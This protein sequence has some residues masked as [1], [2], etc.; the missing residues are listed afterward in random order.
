VLVFALEGT[1][2]YPYCSKIRS[3]LCLQLTGTEVLEGQECNVWRLAVKEGGKRNVYTLWQSVATQL[4]VRYEMFGFDSLLGSHYDKYYIDYIH[5]DVHKS[6]DDA[7]FTTPASE[8]NHLY[9][10][11]AGLLFLPVFVCLLAEQLK[12]LLV[13]FYEILGIGA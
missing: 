2:A 13:D 10:G 9:H 7:I 5:V 12:K 6:L 1:V 8:Y 3:M 4:P 11:V